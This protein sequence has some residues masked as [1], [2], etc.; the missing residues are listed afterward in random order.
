MLR[1]GVLSGGK[2]LRPALVIAAY[3]SCRVPDG[4]GPSGSVGSGPAVS[5]LAAPE[6]TA[7]D[8]RVYDVA[9]SVE[10]IHAYS[11]MHDDLPCMDDAPLRRGRPTTH[12]VFRAW[13]TTVA[14]A[15]L[16]PWAASRAY[17]S[18]LGLGVPRAGAVRV[19][20][21]LLDAAGAGGMVGGQ[22][23]DLMAEGRDLDEVAL[24]GLHRLKTGALLTAALHMGAMAAGASEATEAALLR[25][26]RA[27]GLA[28][29]VRD[30]VLDATAS[31][32]VLGKVPSDAA[33]AKSTYVHLLG[34]EGAEHRCRALMS[35]GLAA[36]DGE[37]LEA[38]ALRALASFV[39]ERER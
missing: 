36:L 15:V 28:F 9:A 2:R 39:I 16:I 24:S 26:G 30:D 38:P 14:A 32:A 19:A 3:E 13:E 17:T 10:L 25:F 34:V 20:R 22:A 31:S 4:L 5:K 8:P 7:S 33:L 18:A 37:G 6:L 12:T 29:Q 35:E 27:V 11:L 21:T 23:L 1:H